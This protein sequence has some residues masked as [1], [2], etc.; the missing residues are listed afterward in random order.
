MQANVRRKM[1]QFNNHQ[2]NN[3]LRRLND[4]IYYAADGSALS[5]VEVVSDSEIDEE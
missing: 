2:T 1:Q 4:E 3:K 5:D